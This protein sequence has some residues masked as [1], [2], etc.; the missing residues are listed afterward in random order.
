MRC[1]GKDS[2]P[3]LVGA[4]ATK[5]EAKIESENDLVKVVMVKEG[6][7]VIDDFRCNRVRV[8]VDKQLNTAPSPGSPQVVEFSL[9]GYFKVI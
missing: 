1:V 8:W 2:W 4:K 9:L 7:Y 3:E 5:T 6:S